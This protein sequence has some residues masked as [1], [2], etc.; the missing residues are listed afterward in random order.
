M[1]RHAEGI[2]RHHIKERHLSGC[3]MGTAFVPLL[4]HH[5]PLTNRISEQLGEIYERFYRDWPK[6]FSYYESAFKLDG[7][8]ADAWFYAGTKHIFTLLLLLLSLGLIGGLGQGLRLQGKAG[9][10]LKYLYRAATLSVPDRAL[11]QWH[12]LYECL[13][14][15][16]LMLLASIQRPYSVCLLVC[17]RASLSM[18]GR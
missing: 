10:A 8:R 17:C 3:Q 4:G 16:R 7:E 5:R 15:C 9:E 18:V 6:A 2:H 12:Y 1:V 13:V 11:F 14:C